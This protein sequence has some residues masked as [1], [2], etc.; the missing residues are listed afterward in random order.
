[1][2]RMI[3][4][5]LLWFLLLL[6]AGVLAHFMV[7]HPGYVMITWGQWMV[8]VTLW[9]AL[10][11]F[12]VTVLIIW[13][14]WRLTRGLNPIRLARQYRDRR[15]RKL[16]RV[17]TE[18]AVKAWLQG[19]EDA[20]LVALDKVIKAGG[21]ERLPQILTL[22]PAQQTG[23]WEERLARVKEADPD[24]AVVG[25]ALEA[26]SHWQAGN[27]TAYLEHMDQHP[28][29]LEVRQLRDRYWRALIEGGRAEEALISVGASPGLNPS[30]RQRWQQE[31]GLALIEQCR[32]SE[33]PDF[34]TLKT[35]PRKVRQQPDLMAAEI[36]CLA[37]HNRLDEAFKR[38]KKAL[39][40]S[41]P[42]ES[43]LRLLV[44]LPFDSAATLKLAEQLA[45]KQTEPGAT[46]NWVLGILCER[47]SLWGKAEDYLVEAWRLDARPEIGLALA[48]LHEH[49]KQIDK[50]QSLYK[51]LALQTE[52]ASDLG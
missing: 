46:L 9:A 42:S 25:L 39:D 43:L 14:V 52:G 27:R 12:V 28:E 44:E 21:S 23:Q 38:L 33:Q 15:D 37:A 29:L 45:G 50:A 13:L 18:K 47:Q 51:T 8:E 11:A 48:R 16:A 17:E 7:R 30:D 5:V 2:S 6:A 41:A 49:R 35:I 4:K 40:S 22:I 36:R 26:D 32:L 1:M 24:L 19:N 10:G 31:A 3:W 34:N 20:S